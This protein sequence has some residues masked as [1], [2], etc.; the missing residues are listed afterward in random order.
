SGVGP[1]QARLQEGQVLRRRRKRVLP[2]HPRRAGYLV[3][4]VE[5]DRPVEAAPG[6]RREELLPVH[7]P[8]A[9]RAVALLPTLRPLLPEEVLDRDHLQARGD[10]V[11]DGAPA[12]VAAFHHRVPD[13]EVVADPPRVEGLDDPG[14]VPDAPTEVAGAVVI[15]ELDAALP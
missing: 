5:R 3:L 11:E 10:Q 13:V 6:Q 12:T 14:D 9:E 2:L 7:H 8:L 1:G 15:A 4:D